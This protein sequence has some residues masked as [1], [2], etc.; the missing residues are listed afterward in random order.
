MSQYYRKKAIQK[1]RVDQVRR[2]EISRLGQQCIKLR[3]N[4]LRLQ[5]DK[6]AICE[7]N[8]LPFCNK[9]LTF[10]FPFMTS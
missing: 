3:E 5:S 4:H 1:V 9:V 6:C 10:L 8:R 7:V 2:L